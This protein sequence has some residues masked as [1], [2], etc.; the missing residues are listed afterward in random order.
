VTDWDSLG[1]IMALQAA[2][3]GTPLAPVPAGV[4]VTAWP[5]R[6]PGVYRRI[7]DPFTG[8]DV[9]VVP[10]LRIDVAVLYASAADAYGNAQHRGFVF[11]DELLAQA[12]DRVILVCEEVVDNAAIRADARATTIPG[13]LVDLVV[14]SAGAAVPGGAPPTYASDLDHLERYCMLA[15][16]QEGADAY[17]ATVRET[18]EHRYVQRLEPW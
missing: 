8:R 2:A 4:E 18:D 12:A 10:A 17:L 16:S 11:W 6:S 14:A 13:Y 15:R 3:S 1:M 7:T 9:T 5:E